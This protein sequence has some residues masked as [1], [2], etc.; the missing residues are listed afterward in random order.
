MNI[1]LT[2]TPTE[3]RKLAIV[4]QRLADASPATGRAP[5]AGNLMEM[6]RALGCIQID[7]IR[8]VERTQYLVLWSRLGAY[9]MD[10]LDRLL[11]D[12]VQLFEYWAH[13]ASIVLTEDYPIHATNMRHYAANS[14]ERNAWIEANPRLHR[15]ILDRLRVDGPLPAK[16]FENLT[17]EP[18]KSNG[19]NNNRNVGM[20]LDFLWRRGEVVIA[21]RSG[22]TRLWHLADVA[23]PAW[24]PQDPLSA[25]ETVHLAAQTSLRNLGVATPRQ[26]TQYFI[27]NRYPKLKT[28]LARLEDEGRVVRAQIQDKG[29]IWPGEWH[30][31]V[32]SLPLLERIQAGDWTPR[33]TLL[34]PFDNLISDRART[35]Q[36]FDFHYRMEIYVPKAKRQYGYYV[37]PIL[38]GDRLIGR[39]NPKMDRK[40]NRLLVENVYA[41]SGAPDSA[42]IGRIVAES[43]A[44]LAKFLGA[45]SVEMAGADAH[46][47]PASWQAGLRGV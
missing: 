15:H 30:I 9:D 42:E 31:H 46:S 38:H 19:W 1:Q 41:E 22:R 35:E 11:Y 45:E 26:I 14:T 34:S 33:T 7:P 4:V 6:T 5:D 20:M 8:A 28:I 21:G 3:A 32:D 37:L 29:E 43:I 27:R 17:D 40:R 23:L 2:L 36:L 47:V 10:L 24:T 12:E 39:V 18:W 25:E 44:G 16:A 13:C